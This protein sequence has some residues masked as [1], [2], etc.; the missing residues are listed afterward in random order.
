MPQFLFLQKIGLLKN[1]STGIFT[2][3]SYW[4]NPMISGFGVP[5][6][7]PLQ[8]SLLQQ[9]PVFF[10]VPWEILQRSTLRL[11]ECYYTNS[12]SSYPLSA[13]DSFE[14]LSEILILGLG[15]VDDWQFLIFFNDCIVIF[16]ICSLHGTSLGDEGRDLYSSS[17]NWRKWGTC[18]TLHCQR[19]MELLIW[20]GPSLP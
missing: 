7:C 9:N 11:G 8:N 18:W 20:D 19:T 4:K 15:D 6:P 3:Q 14:D 1:L 5:F 10:L 17:L 13:N 12:T 16:C 2:F